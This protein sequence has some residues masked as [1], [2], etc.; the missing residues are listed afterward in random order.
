MIPASRRRLAVI[1]LIVA[2]MVAALGGRLWYVQ[3]L[4][5][6]QFK[7][8]ASANQTRNVVVP[9]VRGS[10]VDDE[11]KALV[12]NQTAMVVSV[13]MTQLAQSTS[14]GGTAVL[15]RLAPLLNM[16][17]TALSDKT[18]LCTKGVKAP[19]WSGSP[20]QPIPVAQGVSA[21]TALQIME[22]PK[23]FP[24]VTA[25]PAFT[26]T[27]CFPG[28][29]VSAELYWASRPAWPTRSSPAKPVSA[30]CSLAISAWVIGWR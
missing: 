2:A 26:D 7:T 12:T 25:P 5:G 15:K 30:M 29:P 1:Y 20:Y 22:E 23:Q 21:Q 17:Y 4:S 6:T 16:S 14:D 9:A 18:R 10:I 27:T 11:G 8:L 3:V 19:C 13:N 28:V 24:D